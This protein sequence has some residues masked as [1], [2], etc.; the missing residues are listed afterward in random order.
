MRALM[1]ERNWIRKERIINAMHGERRYAVN[2]SISFEL[3]PYAP[4]FIDLARLANEIRGIDKLF[5]WG[6]NY[7]SDEK[8][9]SIGYLSDGEIV[10]H[11]A[12]RIPERVCWFHIYPTNRHI[13]RGQI[14]AYEK[15]L[16]K[17][18]EELA[19]KKIPGI[20]WINGILEINTV[21]GFKA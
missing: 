11:N 3:S 8:F 21:S 14:Y 20:I 2:G 6:D 18:A 1:L 13:R 10:V 12:S 17:I 19:K 5:P 4:E 16:A 9:T 15:Y 7:R